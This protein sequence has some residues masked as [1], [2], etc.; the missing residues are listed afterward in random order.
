MPHAS[1]ESDLALLRREHDSLDQEETI[2]H[3]SQRL[4]DGNHSQSQSLTGGI[5]SDTD[6][7]SETDDEQTIA[8]IHQIG[9]AALER[10]RQIRAKA[11][12]TRQTCGTETVAATNTEE[13][14]C[15]GVSFP[16]GASSS[17]DVEF[18]DD[19]LRKLVVEQLQ[20]EIDE[21]NKKIV[22]L[23]AGMYEVKATGSIEMIQGATAYFDEAIKTYVE[24]LAELQDKLAELQDKH[25]AGNDAQ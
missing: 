10:A 24:E 12:A 19:D 5:P 16:A 1:S 14:G 17:S 11:V 20:H 18:A 21:Y 9:M 7:S 2:E 13:G 8:Q 15:K 22:R 4:H 23:E 3:C 25:E 6:S